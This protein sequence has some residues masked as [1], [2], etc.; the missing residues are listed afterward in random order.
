MN[1]TQ[2][3]KWMLQTTAEGVYTMKKQEN[4][5]CEPSWKLD[6]NTQGLGLAL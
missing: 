6:I 5:R 3:L 1:T 4:V 2:S